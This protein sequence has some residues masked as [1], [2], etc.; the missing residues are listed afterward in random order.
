MTQIIFVGDTKN[1][2]SL[3]NQT[4]NCFS[5]GLVSRLAT[6]IQLFCCYCRFCRSSTQTGNIL[7]TINGSR[8]T[9]VQVLQTFEK[10]DWE[11]ILLPFPPAWYFRNLKQTR[12][13][14]HE[15]QDN[16]KIIHRTSG[17]LHLLCLQADE[18]PSETCF[19]SI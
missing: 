5:T 14:H 3:H 11:F 17:Y 12:S 7:Y 1:I 18:A 2:Y 8:G 4:D 15:I 16:F 6:N 19:C 10:Q 13:Y 9:R